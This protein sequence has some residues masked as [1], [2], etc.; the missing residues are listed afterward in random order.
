MPESL[1]SYA[2]HL[3]ALAEELPIAAARTSDEAMQL[4]QQAAQLGGTASAVRLSDL[5]ALLTE[6]PD[7]LDTLTAATASA[8]AQIRTV[9]EISRAISL[10]GQVIALAQC[11]A[12][13]Q[14]QAIGPALQALTQGLTQ[15]PGPHTA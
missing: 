15:G 1:Q 9:A 11:V 14:T 8:R 10:T 2:S 4:M 12:T 3:D 13:G 6:A 7:R 5:E